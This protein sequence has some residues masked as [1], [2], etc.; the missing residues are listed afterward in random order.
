MAVIGFLTGR[1][2]FCRRTDGTELGYCAGYVAGIADALVRTGHAC[3]PAEVTV[4]QAVDVV[5]TYLRNHPEQRQYPA[6]YVGRTALGL[7]FPCP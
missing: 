6:W 5:M 2:G 1:W 3:V 4:Q 7:R